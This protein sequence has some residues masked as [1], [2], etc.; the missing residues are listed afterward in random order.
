MPLTTFLNDR[1]FT[2]LRG[3][4]WMALNDTAII[5]RRT[6]TSDTGGGASYAWNAAG[7]TVCRVYPVTL[8]GK[9]ALVGGQINERSTHFCSM[10]PETSVSTSDRIV[11][12]GR[13]TFEV[14][15]DLVASD[16]FTRRVEVIQ[17]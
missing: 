15:V 11:I 16:A 7:T 17:I 8:R 4:Q 6:A 9:G 1:P 14:T 10:P 2:R 5:Q 3:L 13:G 12:G